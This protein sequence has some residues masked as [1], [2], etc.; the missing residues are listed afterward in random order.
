MKK[1]LGLVVATL[2][3]PLFVYAHPGNT[4]SDGCH[5]CRT[6]CDRWGE[7][8]GA[9]HCHGGGYSAPTNSSRNTKDDDGGWFWPIVGT[10][11]FFGVVYLANKD[12][13]K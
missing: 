6:N 3:V 11:G 13:S 5:Y 4:A 9:R 10:A 12:K 7:V 1:I 2:F 8:E